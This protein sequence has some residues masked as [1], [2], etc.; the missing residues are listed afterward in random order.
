MI[1]LS[2]YEPSRFSV[3]GGTV[4]QVES[5]EIFLKQ[6]VDRLPEVHLFARVSDQV[7]ALTVA[8]VAELV[9]ALQKT[10]KAAPSE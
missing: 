7:I 6:N 8:E 5:L 2:L 10:I 4:E 9:V 3:R 1:E